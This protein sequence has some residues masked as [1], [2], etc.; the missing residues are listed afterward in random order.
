M[1]TER[2]AVNVLVVARDPSLRSILGE[3]L[4]DEGFTVAIAEDLDLALTV[5][6]RQSP[7]IVVTDPLSRR[8]DAPALASIHQLVQAAQG[9]RVVLMTPH[10]EASRL[11]SAALGL[12]RILP[13]PFDLADLLDAVRGGD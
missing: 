1:C 8:W 12:S 9:A 4:R 6:A 13:A 5:L 2:R 3:A 10:A 11:D 7:D